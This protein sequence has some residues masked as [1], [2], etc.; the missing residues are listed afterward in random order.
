MIKETERGQSG[1]LGARRALE[2]ERDNDKG[3]VKERERKK[4]RG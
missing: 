1:S 4:G 2:R 3:R